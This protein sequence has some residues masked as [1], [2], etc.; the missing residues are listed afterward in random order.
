M[1]NDGINKEIYSKKFVKIDRKRKKKTLLDG[2]S[3]GSHPM[4][5]SPAPIAWNAKAPLTTVK[6]IHGTTPLL[7]S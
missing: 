1:R 4:R 6:A 3:D 2:T 5:S 7:G